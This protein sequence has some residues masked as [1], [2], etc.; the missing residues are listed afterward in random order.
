VRWH[1]VNHMDL[2]AHVPHSLFI[3]RSRIAT[4]CE[5]EWVSFLND[6]HLTPVPERQDQRG[7]F[8]NWA[9]VFLPDAFPTSL[10]PQLSAWMEQQFDQPDSGY[11]KPPLIG[12]T[13]FALTSD[14][15]WLRIQL[16]NFA[17]G[18]SQVR[19]FF[20]KS[21]ALVAPR[22]TFDPELLRRLDFGMKSVYFYMDVALTLYIVAQGDTE[23]KL[24]HLQRWQGG[25]LNEREKAAV[26]GFIEG[27]PVRNPLLFWLTEKIAYVA[28]RI[29]CLPTGPVEDAVLPLGIEL[30]TVWARIKD[31]PLF[32]SYIE[33]KRDQVDKLARTC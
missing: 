10:Q 2:P 32:S 24:V 4:I 1:S 30:S 23:E 6:N 12:S 22:I 7:F 33:L 5:E 31:H 28:L 27:R 26:K 3:D 9:A 20:H 8:L 14:Q 13:L 25:F 29:G 17:D 16:D 21:L 18:G 19:T 11:V 15:H